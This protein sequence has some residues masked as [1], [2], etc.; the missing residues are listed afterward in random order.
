MS[1]VEVT[2]SWKLIGWICLIAFHL[3]P[4]ESS[5]CPPED[6]R[7]ERYVMCEARAS[8]YYRME[9]F[10]QHLL[11]FPDPHYKVHWTFNGKSGPWPYGSSSF[12]ME[13]EGTLESSA[14]S[15]NDAGNYTCTV[16]SSNGTSASREFNLCVTI[17]A[18]FG[19]PPFVMETP[20]NPKIQ[21][22]LPGYKT[23]FQCNAS[24]G[25]PSCLNPYNYT[26]EWWRSE[27]GV[28]IP[29]RDSEDIRIISAYGKK[30]NI[31][32]QLEFKKVKKSHYGTYNCV[33]RNAYGTL[34]I[35]YTLERGVDEA[36]Y[37][38][39][40]YQIAI[41]M[42]GLLF[43]MPV[44]VCFC[45][46]FRL[47]IALYYK[48][49]TTDNSLAGRYKYDIYVVCGETA[50]DWVYGILLPTLEE[51]YGYKC[52]IP[53]RNFIPGDRATHTEAKISKS[54]KTRSWGYE[55]VCSLLANVNFSRHN[56]YIEG[57]SI[58][59]PEAYINSLLLNTD[60]EIRWEKALKQH[61]H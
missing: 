40:M 51:T 3:S 58:P 55:S 28:W 5:P 35:N 44:A 22:V 45:R 1:L 12:I 10:P 6:Q 27:A 50:I 56:E 17:S 36:E 53:D 48:E 46:R 37:F 29:L 59:H 11:G 33:V 26:I 42:V 38:T 4:S 43:I 60:R 25:N 8:K 15:T 23:S 61:V 14:T 16:T 52:L 39:R 20:E 49:K 47:V 7:G 41:V 13:E 54:T 21:R 32:S 31:T 34:N 57:Y 2:T 19:K 24:V 9:C 18:D 30:G